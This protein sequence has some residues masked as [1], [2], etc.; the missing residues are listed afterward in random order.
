MEATLDLPNSTRGIPNCHCN[1]TFSLIMLQFPAF[2]GL[3]VGRILFRKDKRQQDVGST[4][5]SM[6]D[7]LVLHNR[8]TRIEHLSG[9]LRPRN[10]NEDDFSATKTALQQTKRRG[11]Q[12]NEDDLQRNSNEYDFSAT[13]TALQQTKRRGGQRNEDVVQRK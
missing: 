11:G 4:Y 1:M 7:F 12:R 2:S 5:F 13:K 10:S 6:D 3:L 8:W 9:A